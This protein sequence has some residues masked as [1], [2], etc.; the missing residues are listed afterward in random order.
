MRIDHARPFLAFVFF[1]IVG[2]GLV[3]R[4]ACGGVF[5]PRTI[6]WRT[7]FESAWTEAAETNRPL[8]IQFTGPW[9]IYCRRMDLETFLNPTI[10]GISHSD[11]VPVKVRTDEREDLAT[12]FQVFSLPTTIVLSP[13]GE[14]LARHGGYA[15]PQ[16]L[17]AL[18]SRARALVPPAQRELALQGACVVR[19]V[20]HG[21]IALGRENISETFDGRV[22]RFV[23]E[24]SRDRFRE[25]PE[26]FVPAAGGSSVVARV[27]GGA[28]QPGDPRLGV[29]HQERLYLFASEDERQAF[30]ENPAKYR[31]ADLANAGICPIC[32]RNLVIPVPGSAKITAIHNGRRYLFH[33]D[34]HRAAFRESPDRYVR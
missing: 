7:S 11:V 28:D 26:R 25:N 9:C 13:K 21:E 1:L 34:G 30:V 33:A 5:D 17:Q 6:P 14:I 3:D 20:E 2:A 24:A 16:A 27:D 10:V 23:D 18:L 22:Y 4:R 12:R 15:S 32:Q 8:W 31:D 29:Y 19:L